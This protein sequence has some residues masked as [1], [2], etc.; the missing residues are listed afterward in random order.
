V[1]EASTEPSGYSD[2]ARA[3]PSPGIKTSIARVGA[4]LT[5]ER[6][7]L[8]AAAAGSCSA[9]LNVAAHVI[10]THRNVCRIGMGLLD[11]KFDRL[12]PDASEVVSDLDEELV[13]AAGQLGPARLESL[14]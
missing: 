4:K 7:P 12:A 13:T 5:S 1:S 8:S 3:A 11:C 2:S 6:S 10:S 9:R 14:W